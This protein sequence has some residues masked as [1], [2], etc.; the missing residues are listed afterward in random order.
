VYSLYPHCT[1]RRLQNLSRDFSLVAQTPR[2][3]G[4]HTWS[5]FRVSYRW[6]IWSIS[7]QDVV[8]MAHSWCKLPYALNWTGSGISMGCLGIYHCNTVHGLTGREGLQSPQRWNRA[9]RLSCW[10]PLRLH[11]N[12]QNISREDFPCAAALCRVV[13]N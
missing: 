7:G 5:R 6:V 9:A 2:L 1:F 10:F 11:R 12:L 13:P 4:K 8:R 3:T